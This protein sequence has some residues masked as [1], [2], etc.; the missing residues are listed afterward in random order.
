MSGMFVFGHRMRRYD[1]VDVAWGLVFI[2]VTITGLL[3][4]GGAHIV[5]Y[6]VLG[7]VAVWGLRLGGHIYRRLRSSTSE[8]KRYVEMRKKWQAKNEAA[9]IFFRVYMVQALLATMVCLPAIVLTDSADVM[10]SPVVGSGFVIWL[11]GFS[12]EVLSDR[13]LRL[14]IANPDNKGQLMTQGLWR[15]SRHPNYF[16]ELTLWWGL[17]IMALSVPFGWISLVGPTLISF[18]IIFISGIPPTERA[19]SGRPGWAE[20]KRR[21]SVLIPWV[22][23]KDNAS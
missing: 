11:I 20:Y 12:I 6:L 22:P 4:S 1:I 2:V 15:Y 23:K 3:M 14:F 8:D 5:Q 17:G 10:L 18:L 7:M 19:F 16:G 21:T 9:A 13:Q